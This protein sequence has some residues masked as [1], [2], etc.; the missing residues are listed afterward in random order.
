MGFEE[1]RAAMLNIEGQEEFFTA[2]Q[3]SSRAV[4]GPDGR[5]PC[6]CKDNPTEP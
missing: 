1:I 4:T 6:K 5:R 3:I 2:G